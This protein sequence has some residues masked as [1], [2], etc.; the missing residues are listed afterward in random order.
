M[1]DIVYFCGEDMYD[2]LLKDERLL[3]SLFYL[4]LIVVI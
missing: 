4:I 3:K 2:Y 1:E